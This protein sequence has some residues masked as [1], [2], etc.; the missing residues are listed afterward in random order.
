MKKSLLILFGTL[1]LGV[2]P[3]SGAAAQS[4]QMDAAG[5][6]LKFTAEQM[7]AAFDGTFHQ[8]AASVSFAPGNLAASS[9]DVTVDPASADTQEEQR[10]ATL[11]GSDFFDVEHF[12]SAHFSTTT[13]RTT[14]TGTFEA[15]GKLTLRDTTRDVTIAFSFD[16]RKEGAE[17]VSYLTGS[18]NLKRLDFGIGRGEYVDT[19]AVGND[20]A[21]R[22][23][24]R[25][26][27]TAQPPQ[28]KIPTPP[29]PLQT[30]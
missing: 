10:D 27:P 29:A 30:K 20:V 7:G 24:L 4:Y 26:L 1:L 19:S 9:L 18:A 23:S 11:R 21:I 28:K 5:S 3:V 16:S 17:N 12:K 14:K 8:F 2:P 25:L 22:F 15:I 6:S 13:F